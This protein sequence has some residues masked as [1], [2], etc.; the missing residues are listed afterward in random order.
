MRPTVYVDYDNTLHDTDSKYRELLDG[1]LGLDGATLWD[2]FLNKIH[3][4]EIHMRH[5]ERH[6]DLRFHV[7]LLL[8]RLGHEANPKTISQVEEAFKAAE[9]ECVENPS[10]F[11]DAFSFLKGVRE[12]RYRLCLATG[13]DAYEKGKALEKRMGQRVFDHIFG[14]D[15]LR[16][17]KTEPAYYLRALEVA[18]ATSQQSA[19]V[20][21]TIMTDIAPAKMAGLITIWLNRECKPLTEGAAAPDR[22]VRSLGEA[23]ETLKNIFSARISRA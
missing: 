19:I 22:Q 14:E 12:A 15:D 18:K 10:Y 13:P 9:R 20:G 4:G 16:C 11:P 17:L 5:P 3:R 21:D 6:N 7:V 1:L 23:L 8:E 2:L